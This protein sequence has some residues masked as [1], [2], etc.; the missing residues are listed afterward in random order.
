[1]FDDEISTRE[2][3]E[4]CKR[5]VSILMEMCPKRKKYKTFD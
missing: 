4:I 1:M 5:L 2:L 3:V